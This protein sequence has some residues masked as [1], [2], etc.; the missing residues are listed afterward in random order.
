[1]PSHSKHV[2]THLRDAQVANVALLGGAGG[3]QFE[4]S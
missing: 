1:M 3:M 4:A 2:L